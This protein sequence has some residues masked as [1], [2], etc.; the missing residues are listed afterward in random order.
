MTLWL[1]PRI[2][3]YFA[4]GNFKVAVLNALES[5]SLEYT[6]VYTGFFIDG[7]VPKVPTYIS[8]L[9][10]VLDIAADTAAIPGTGDNKV[11]FT[12]TWDVAKYVAKLV[13]STEWDKSS[14]IIGDKI[15]WNEFVAIV[16]EAKGTKFTIHYDSIETLRQGQITELPS[17]VHMYPFFPKPMLQ[18][19]FA[20]FGRTFAEDGFDLKP[21]GTLNDKFKIPT[22]SVKQLV[23]ESWQK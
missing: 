15:T 18:N 3:E 14:Y 19:M 11:V 5:T 17:H 9:P 2:N 4:F 21:K 16:E 12:H 23:V 10:L 20:A 1:T 6:A 13:T 8:P 22:R 7:W